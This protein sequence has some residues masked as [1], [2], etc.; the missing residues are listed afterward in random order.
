MDVVK[1][2][3]LFARLPNVSLRRIVAVVKRCLKVLFARSADAVVVEN[4]AVRGVGLFWQKV[5]RLRLLRDLGA[6]TALSGV[7]D[8][9][10]I[11]PGQFYIRI[12]VS[13]RVAQKR[14]CLFHL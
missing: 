13:S 6:E 12:L 11:F 9:I 2:L 4:F 1:L 10:G 7:V 14:L 3:A 8:Q 5:D